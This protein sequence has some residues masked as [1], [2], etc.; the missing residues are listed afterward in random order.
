MNLPILHNTSS[1]DVNAFINYWEKFYDE[2]YKE[3]YF[4]IITKPVWEISD[5]DRLF[6]WKNNMGKKEKKLGKT[7]RIYVEKVVA[8][9]DWVN[10]N[11]HKISYPDFVNRFKKLGPIWS[12]TLLHAM[13]PLSYPIYDQ[14]VHRAYCFLEGKELEE[15]KTKDVYTRYQNEYLLFFKTFTF[16]V[17]K[18]Y[19][20]MKKV[21]NALWAFGKYLK[22]YSAMLVAG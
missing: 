21:D 5:I 17:V 18:E 1:K 16:D 19:A 9:L 14:H 12:I 10:E 15:L 7:K 2:R 8:N 4:E 6:K 11:R 3:D 20:Q 22:Q 13:E